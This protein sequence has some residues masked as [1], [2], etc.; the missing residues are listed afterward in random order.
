MTTLSRSNPALVGALAA[1][2]AVFLFSLGDMLAKLLS[3]DY[4]LHQLILL[5]ALVGMAF[6]LA[7]VLPFA[8]G[9]AALGT[10]RPGLHIA[11]GI[12]VV[13]SNVALFLGLAALPL[14]E[15][16]AIFF[17]CPLIIT[18]LSVVVLR[19]RVGP[20]RWGAVALGLV[21]VVVIL[22]PGTEAF[23]PAALFPIAAAAAY[24]VLQ[25]LTRRGGG[26]ESAAT[27]AFT[28]QAAFILVCGLAGLL[29]GD[30][31]FAGSAD[32]AFAFA[33]RAWVWPPAADLPLFLLMGLASGLG[34][35]LISVAYRGTDAGVVA[36][37]EYVAMPL[38]L[39]WGLVVFAEWPDGTALAGIALILAAGLLTVWRET[40]RRR[41]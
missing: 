37:F 13:L 10:R 28:V 40:R 41:S 17:I 36:T 18:A 1:L 6:L 7:A 27:L 25:I 26:T 39:F 15:A 4:A 38:A 31:R 3:G 9:F 19:E 11:R 21:G 24:A 33:L 32:P 14:A 30:G 5:R 16:V 12:A 2:A 23:Q 34:G 29:L 20:W 8:G 35:W 22:R